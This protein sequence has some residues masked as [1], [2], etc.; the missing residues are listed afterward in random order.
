MMNNRILIAIIGLIFFIGAGLGVWYFANPWD[1]Q[2]EDANQ[3]DMPSADKTPDDKTP[4]KN[5]TGAQLAPVSDLRQVDTYKAYQEAMK[6][7]DPDGEKVPLVTMYYFLG[8][9]GMDP[10]TSKN[11]TVYFA[12]Q[13]PEKFHVIAYDYK[14]GILTEALAKDEK[15]IGNAQ[16]YQVPE[17]VIRFGFEGAMEAVVS[18]EEYMK[19]KQQHPGLFDNYSITVINDPKYGWEWDY[20]ASQLSTRKMMSFAVK[21]DTA[22]VIVYR[23]YLGENK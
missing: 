18:N 17:Q 6:M 11:D 23:A 3:T 4:S 16:D 20:S 8:I 21:P 15:G 13:A 5:N 7:V 22:K 12:F 9:Q 2:T 10:N 19:N 14:T 1:R